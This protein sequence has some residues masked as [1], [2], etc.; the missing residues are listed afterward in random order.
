M[1]T[2]GDEMPERMTATLD[3]GLTLFEEGRYFDAHEIWEEEWVDAPKQDRDFLQGLIHVAICL[4]H[5]GK[6]NI[7]GAALQ[8]GKALSRLDGLPDVHRGVSLRNA[9]A[10][11]AQV[12][13][14]KGLEVQA[15][16]LRVK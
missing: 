10:F 15:P 1:K 12:I 13:D 4:H 3:E 5:A 7:R 11:A 14:L 8:A 9:R 6:G 16:V 2:T